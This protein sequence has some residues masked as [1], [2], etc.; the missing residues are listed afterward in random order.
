MPEFYSTGTVSVASAGTTVT[1]TGGLWSGVLPGDTIEIGDLPAKTIASPT[2]ANHL[3]L[4]VAVTA[5]QVGV[6]YVLRFDAPQRFTSG[7][8]AEQ[9]RGMIARAGIIKAAAPVYRVQGIPNAP[10]VSPVAGDFYL[11]WTAPTGA[12]VGQAN[13]LAQW[14]GSAWQFTTTEGGWLVYNIAT[15]QQF[16]RGLS[17]WQVYVPPSAYMATVMDDADAATAR[18]TLGLADVLRYGAQTLTTP[19]QAQAQANIGLGK[20]ARVVSV[21]TVSAAVAA[22]DVVLPAG[23][24]HFKLFVQNLTTGGNQVIFG[25]FSYDN[26]ATFLTATDSYSNTSVAM[27]SATFASVFNQLAVQMTLSS[28]WEANLEAGIFPGGVNQRAGILSTENAFTTGWSL[29][30]RSNKV[31]TQTGR[32]TTLR[33]LSTV[34]FTANNAKL[35]LV[36]YPE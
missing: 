3:E 23:Y 7:Y 17:G 21:T 30:Q 4:A 11:V 36:G 29:V 12:W 34:N 26:G 27:S 10:P 22:I 15:G 32:V 31:Y 8:L 6:P 33:L 19:Q 9:V 28:S 1:L 24:S 13:N 14:T 35:T 5:D 16:I 18:A 25:R 2:D 20:A